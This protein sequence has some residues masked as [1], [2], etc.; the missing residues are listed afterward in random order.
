MITYFWLLN[1][2][3]CFIYFEK[4][5]TV[6]PRPLI[7]FFAGTFVC[8]APPLREEAADSLRG[9]EERQ[10]EEQGQG[11]RLTGVPDRMHSFLK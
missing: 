2:W 11:E 5:K 3:I 8:E 6:R 10:G 9:Q 4:Q 7:F 1:I